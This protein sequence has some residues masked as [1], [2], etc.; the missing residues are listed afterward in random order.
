M[1]L[2]LIA[3]G[4][5]DPS[6]SEGGTATDAPTTTTI[7]A[8]LLPQLRQ[9][10]SGGVGRIEEWIE[11]WNLVNDAL[12][13]ENSEFPRILLESD[14]FTV[15]GGED[16]FPVFTAQVG[17]LILGGVVTAEDGG[18]TSLIL[19]G[20][21]QDQSFFAAYSIWLGALDP[22]V[23]LE[24]L[25]PVEVVSGD[26]QRSVVESNGRTYEAFRVDGA[27][28]VA[29]SV[30]MVGGTFIDDQAT[31]SAHSVVRR[32]VLGALAAETGS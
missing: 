10:G 7:Q 32:N 11:T 26:E 1:T 5:A 16:G 2:L 15:R 6:S 9:Q 4:D 27:S 21:P 8:P 31:F 13:D 17:D 30:S 28:G 14:D 23:A 18:I 3:C 12:V 22:T 20:Q 29:I 24:Q 25:L 19:L